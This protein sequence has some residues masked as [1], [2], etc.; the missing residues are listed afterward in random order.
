M[1]DQQISRHIRTKKYAYTLELD[2]KDF[3]IGGEWR[4]S[5]VPDFMWRPDELPSDAILAKIPGGYPLSYAKVKELVT[6]ASGQTPVVQP[7]PNPVVDNPG[8]NDPTAPTTNSVTACRSC[9]LSMAPGGLVGRS[10]DGIKNLIRRAFLRHGVISFINTT[11][12]VTA[13]D[14]VDVPIGF[15]TTQKVTNMKAWLAES[16]F[17]FE[18]KSVTAQ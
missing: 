14:K 18:L 2:D 8:N 3:V 16:P 11:S 13:S 10:N 15:L 1:T 9:V 17:N 7:P 6:A 4:S 12:I 5:A